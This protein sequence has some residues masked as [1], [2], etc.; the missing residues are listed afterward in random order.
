MNK[1]LLLLSLVAGNC[2][3]HEGHGLP[4]SHIHPSDWYL[5]LGF[6]VVVVAMILAWRSH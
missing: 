2:L 4:A 3:A 1:I 6:G 5:L